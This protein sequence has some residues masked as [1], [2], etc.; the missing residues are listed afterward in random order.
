MLELCFVH[1]IVSSC[2]ILFPS[3]LISDCQDIKPVHS[4]GWIWRTCSNIIYTQDS[5]LVEE[6]RQPWNQQFSSYGLEIFIL[7]HIPVQPVKNSTRNYRYAG[8]VTPRNCSHS[9]ITAELEHS[10]FSIGIEVKQA[11][12][13]CVVASSIL[14]ELEHSKF[15]LAER[16]NKLDHVV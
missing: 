5:S 2:V 9:S 4:G 3:F 1:L 13:C 10:K 7:C 6:T 14:A 11:G 12:P 16:W 8:A 15:P